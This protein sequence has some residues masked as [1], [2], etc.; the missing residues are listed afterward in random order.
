MDGNLRVQAA[1]GDAGL[2]VLVGDEAVVEVS[3]SELATD[4]VSTIYDE[5]AGGWQGWDDWAVCEA[6]FSKVERQFMDALSTLRDRWDRVLEWKRK[7]QQ[8]WPAE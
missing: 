4:Y 6:D 5:G 3:L 7:T 2:V 1:I 8:T